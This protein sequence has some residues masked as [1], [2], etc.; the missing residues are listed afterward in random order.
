VDTTTATALSENAEIATDVTAETADTETAKVSASGTPTAPE[1]EG[2][3]MELVVD[4]DALRAA[5]GRV[6]WAVP[7]RTPLPALTGIL[8]TAGEN[9][10]RLCAC[11]PETVAAARCRAEVAAPGQ[12]LV[13]ARLLKDLAERLPPG[14]IGLAAGE[15][16]ASLRVS[17]GNGQAKLA[18]LPAKEYPAERRCT[19]PG[20]AIDTEQWTAA[21]RHTAF[22][23]AEEGGGR[24]L[25]T[26]IRMRLHPDGLDALTCNGICVARFCTEGGQGKPTAAATILARDAERAAAAF[27]DTGSKTLTL[28]IEPA[29]VEIAAGDLCVQIAQLE[30]S[31][32][33]IESLLPKGYSEEARINRTDLA[34]T[35]GRALVVGKPEN[36]YLVR[37]GADEQGL[38]LEASS[39]DAGTASEHLAGKV[40]PGFGINLNG[41]PLGEALR[42]FSGEQVLIE[43]DPD[44]KAPLRLTGEDARLTYWQMPMRIG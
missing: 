14:A 39:P 38:T 2:T 15:A 10:L 26:G 17:W 34:A 29:F 18:C 8:L 43:T 3:A 28:R 9:G 4:R 24:P 36:L 5:L 30:G 35:L 21:V 22:C 19:H 6:A 1:G 40:S 33:D 44:K 41:R 7:S 12:A 32:P 23:A 13:P 25:L 37:I 16:G 31:Y 11:T 27:S 42:H 20:I